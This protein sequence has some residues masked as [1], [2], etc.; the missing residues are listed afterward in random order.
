M[1]AANSLVDGPLVVRRGSEIIRTNAAAQM[2]MGIRAPLATRDSPI[3]AA[4]FWQDHTASVLASR[5]PRVVERKSLDGVAYRIRT[6]PVGKADIVVDMFEPLATEDRRQARLQHF[7][8]QVEAGQKMAS[9]VRL[10]GSVAHDLNNVMTAIMGLVWVLRQDLGA[11]HPNLEEV[12]HVAEALDR[13]RGLT[14][15]LLEQVRE[16]RLYKQRFSLV[17]VVSRVRGLLRVVKP[18]SVEV[19]IEI[20]EELPQLEGDAVA[21]GHALMNL[22]RNALDAMGGGGTLT[23]SANLECGE[24]RFIAIEVRDTGEGMDADTVAQAAQPYFSGRLRDRNDRPGLGLAKV[25]EVAPGHGG[26]LHLQSEPGQGT[27]ARMLLP[28]R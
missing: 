5:E 15:E 26:E 6:V 11:D 12:K 19:A 8:D 28:V 4:E 23:I 1:D 25:Q 27:R 9:V 3:Y 16:H 13:G 7:Q 2:L 24:R 10:A 21:I 14:R 22:C 17:D 20:D 18:T